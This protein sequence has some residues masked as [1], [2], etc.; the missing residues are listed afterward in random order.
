MSTHKIAQQLTELGEFYPGTVNSLQSIVETSVVRTAD[1]IGDTFLDRFHAAIELLG[2]T[3]YAGQARIVLENGDL[4]INDTMYGA[5]AGKTGIAATLHGVEIVGGINTRIYWADQDGLENKVMLDLPATWYCSFHNFALVGQRIGTTTTVSGT[6][7]IRIRSAFEFNWVSGRNNNLYNIAT[8]ECAIGIGAGSDWGDDITSWNIW[9]WRP[10]NCERG[11]VMRGG[12]LAF[13][14]FRHCHVGFRK[15]N[16]IGF[17]MQYAVPKYFTAESASVAAAAAG[18]T[19][20]DTIRYTDLHGNFVPLSDFDSSEIARRRIF[21]SQDRDANDPS[22]DASTAR[23]IGGGPDAVFRNCGAN[24]I[25]ATPSIPCHAFELSGGSVDIDYFRLEGTGSCVAI[26]NALPGGSS[27]VTDR[28]WCKFR[29]VTTSTTQTGSNFDAYKL[30]ETSTITRGYRKEIIGGH[31][32]N[33]Q[34]PTEDVSET[35]HTSLY[36]V[37][38]EQDATN[39][40]GDVVAKGYLH[41]KTPELLVDLDFAELPTATTVKDHGTLAA[42]WTIAGSGN[43]SQAGP[44]TW[45][46]TLALNNSAYLTLANSGLTTLSQEKLNLLSSRGFAAYLRFNTASD[47]AGDDDKRFAG[48]FGRGDPTTDGWC[49]TFNALD[50]SETPLRLRYQNTA[51]ILH[52]TLI[53]PQRWN[54]MVL[55]VTRDAKVE[56]FLNGQLTTKADL[57]TTWPD[58]SSE[59]FYLGVDGSDLSRI[60]EGQ[61]E[62]FRLYNRALDYDE[63]VRMTGN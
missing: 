2:S 6:I 58:D 13:F 14:T 29:N 42:N 36:D 28:S 63:A 53:R 48:L 49:F 25:Q 52:G 16:G 41:G 38:T 35:K 46:Q 55:S 8:E 26:E 17:S 20:P 40:G 31:Y 19:D 27:F 1:M 51:Q 50:S 57:S 21:D 45:G 44:G 37:I 59:D 10:Y 9:N 56:V 7:G 22:F 5:Y 61:V 3:D 4:E 47:G 33:G 39:S 62:T 18:I 32:E 34:L 23:T 43:T 60:L 54:S 11:L 30:Q 12:N 15:D 24:F